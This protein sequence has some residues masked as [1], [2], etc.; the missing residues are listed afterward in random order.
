[1]ARLGTKF[2]STGGTSQCPSAG[3]LSVS[4]RGG[5]G[6]PGTS[7]YQIWYRNIALFCTHAASNTSNC[8]EIDWGA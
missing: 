1:V 8:W 4:V 7:T 3:D 2:S 6:S 5:V